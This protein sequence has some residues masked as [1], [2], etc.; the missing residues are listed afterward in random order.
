MLNF[1][2][3]SADPNLLKA[4]D[5]CVRFLLEK[6]KLNPN[7]KN[8]LLKTSFFH[9]VCNRSGISLQIFRVLFDA[10]AD[11]NLEDKRGVT[12][13]L[14]SWNVVSEEVKKLFLANGADVTK[15]LPKDL[16]GSLGKER[17]VVKVA[18]KK[19]VSE[20]G[21]LLQ[22]YLH[23]GS[24]WR[25]ETHHL[26]PSHFRTPIFTF[27]LCLNRMEHSSSEN[28]VV[29]KRVYNV[30]KPILMIIIFLS[31]V[32]RFSKECEPASTE[33]LN[34]KEEEVPFWSE[35]PTPT[36]KANRNKT[37]EEGEGESGESTVE[38]ECTQDEEETEESE[39]EEKRFEVKPFE[40][41]P[42]GGQENNVFHFQDLPFQF[43][44]L[45]IEEKKEEQVSAP[46]VFGSSEASQQTFSFNLGSVPKRNTRKDKK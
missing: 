12:P 8:H 41:K 10:K 15:V 22:E 19:V 17:R 40:V 24:I 23:K 43:S 7:K 46:F 25:K 4:T 44:A 28:S 29:M 32:R 36:K 37:R 26:F 14:L 11:P 27:L 9:S 38:E 20:F 5:E 34:L 2:K 35:D 3:D 30:P 1:Y 6:K 21:L 16:S 13:T 42:F 31:S 45:S 18:R 33:P 39:E